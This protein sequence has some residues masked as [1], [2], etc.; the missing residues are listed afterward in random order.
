MGGLSDQTQYSDQWV[1]FYPAVE[2]KSKFGKNFD[3][4]LPQEYTDFLERF[5]KIVYISFGTT[6][7]PN[8]EKLVKIVDAIVESN[9]RYKNIGYIFALKPTHP[10]YD[11][12]LEKS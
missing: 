5:D 1:S 7:N 2:T 11:Y 8:Y 6:Y 9:E 4:A 3:G 12:Y 10:A